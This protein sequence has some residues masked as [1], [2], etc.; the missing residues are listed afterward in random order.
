LLVLALLVSQVSELASGAEVRHVYDGAVLMTS[1]PA[2]AIR[3][4][5]RTRVQVV[6]H[7][8]TAALQ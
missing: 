2:I 8:K 6:Q 1:R 5:A 7:K 4:R 3:A